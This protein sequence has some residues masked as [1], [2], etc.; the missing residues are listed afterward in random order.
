MRRLTSCLI[1]HAL[2]AAPAP[3]LAEAQRVWVL[4]ND[5]YK[6][7]L[8]L[9]FNEDFPCL[10]R[11]L[12][13]EWGLRE[14]LLAQVVPTPDTCLSRAA[15][16]P[17]THYYYDRIAQLITFTFP[18]KDVEIRPNGVS[19]SRWDEGITALFVNYHLN[20][21]WDNATRSEYEPKNS[22]AWL[23]L[24][25]GLNVGPWRLRYQNSMLR[26]KTGE[27]TSYTRRFSLG[28]NIQSWRS[29]FLAGEGDTP[30]DLFD[31]VSFRGVMLNSDESMLPDRWR[32]FSPRIKGF[33]KS[34]AEVTL[35]QRGEVVYRTFVFPGVF[36]LDNIYPPE[37][38]G[39][40]EITV[41]ESDGTESVRIV[42]YA[43]M[44]NLV[45]E[46]N[47]NYQLV[48]GHY[49]PWRGS[50]LPRPAFVQ[51]ALFAGLPGNFSLFGGVIHTSLYDSQALGIG[52]NLGTWGALSLD[53]T[54]SRATQPRRKSDDRGESYR[55]RYAKAF[56][57]TG[58]SISMQLRYYPAGRRYRSFQ[59]AV[60]QQKTW[61]WDWDDNG[62][63]D[64]DED[65][66]K[67]WRAE[68]NL[69]QNLWQDGNLY[70]TYWQEAFR[71]GG[72]EHSMM[73]G[74]SDTFRDVDYSIYASY[75][76]A[77]GLRG[78][79]EVNFTVSIPFSVFLGEDRGRGMRLNTE[80]TA[81]NRKSARE[82]LTTING[83]ALDDYSLRYQ[84]GTAYNAEKHGSLLANLDYQHNAGEIRLGTTQRP[85]SR[86]YDAD[87]TGSVM[88]HPGGV[89]LGQ[90][91]GD[92][93]ALVEIPGTAGIGIDNQ[94]G[95][96]TDK[97]GYALVS[98]MTPYRVNRITPDTL[99]LP[100]NMTLPLEEVDV[101]PTAGAVAFARF[102]SVE[103]SE[104][105]EGEDEDGNAEGEAPVPPPR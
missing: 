40:L 26:E 100:E 84:L 19:T 29:R 78:N 66:E 70:L 4:V 11:P 30:S 98:Y 25:S 5:E 33:A 31:S 15:L 6:G 60:N 17:E 42:P 86:Q 20:Y 71:R 94:F 67:R 68:L 102:L 12:L 105:E 92:T 37:A 38:N 63:W 55:L 96:T 64:G 72:K 8:L 62:N 46:G 87:V 50:E 49:K 3:V 93:M 65:P 88:V 85:H 89:T 36:T 75:D 9:D 79:K 59:Q 97:N 21:T 28:R 45:H 18:E 83:S 52:K 51:G 69:N 2:L 58:T 76:K 35:R 53:V 41:K 47:V 13:E 104:D 43:S 34:N 56:F 61:W 103:W 44:P 81:A 95:V 82:A 14:Q 54:H 23:E 10:R 73:L 1:L 90:T 32:A 22:N 24:D 7:E 48:Y 16:P 77:P 80:Y 99:N 74:Y 57:D 27:R 101:V 91:L 39:D